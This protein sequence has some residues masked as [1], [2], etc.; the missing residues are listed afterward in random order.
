M[1]VKRVSPDE[2]LAL[3]Q[4][5]GYVYLDVRSVPEFEAGH[6]EGAYNV[7]LLDMGPQGMTPNPA[8]LDVVKAHF[9]PEARLVVG[10][11][12]GGRSLRAAT[13]L[14]SNG[15][16]QVV[17]QRAG[18]DGSGEPGWSHRGLPVSKTAAP[19]RRYAELAAK[20]R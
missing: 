14:E 20:A 1:P 13:L 15:Y 8:F 12:A 11:K 17:D 4:K 5:E 9:P 19:E 10:C 3:M 7:P 16:T 2:A 6:P 18:F